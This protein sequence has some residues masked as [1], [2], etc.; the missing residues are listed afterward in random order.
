MKYNW[1]FLDMA[2]EGRRYPPNLRGLLAFCTESTRTE[3]ASNTS[4]AVELD[5]EVSCIL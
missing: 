2:D 1:F 4:A 5:E 3:D